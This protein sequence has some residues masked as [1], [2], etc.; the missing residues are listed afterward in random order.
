MF[1]LDT[2]TFKYHLTLHS[3]IIFRKTQ[4]EY[5]L[6]AFITDITCGMSQ[7]IYR[8]ALLSWHW[9]IMREIIVPIFVYTFC[10][11]V[12]KIM[13]YLII[14]QRSILQSEG[15]AI[16]SKISQTAKHEIIERRD[17]VSLAEIS[18]V[19]LT[20][21]L[22]LSLRI[23]L[24]KLVRCKVQCL[25][26]TV[27][28][29]FLRGAIND[30]PGVRVTWPRRGEFAQCI[31]NQ[32]PR[33]LSSTPVLPRL[34]TR[35]P[36]SSDCL[37]HPPAHPST[38]RNTIL[39]SRLVS[40]YPTLHFSSTLRAHPPLGTATELVRLPPPPPRFC[41]LHRADTLGVLN[42]IVATLLLATSKCRRRRLRLRRRR[43]QRYVARSLAHSHFLVAR[44]LASFSDQP[45]FR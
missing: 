16:W 36:V 3:I 33:P 40:W 34:S 41:T 21:S 25:V 1:S 10:I 13:E 19:H 23:A 44:N 4:P 30:R 20:I 14:G 26:G 37:R 12:I 8:P 24:R 6:F 5:L 32:P 11:F 18:T 17:G 29:T 31:T 27:C 7:R 45:T 39:A 42:G 9:S 15:H 43:R 22:S 2:H 35:S 38:P 28:P